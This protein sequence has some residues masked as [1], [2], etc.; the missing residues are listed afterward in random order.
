MMKTAAIRTLDVVGLGSPARRVASRL[1]KIAS[2]LRDMGVLPWKPLVPEAALTGCLRHALRELRRREP[3]AALGD[4]LEF[5]VSRG[6]SMACAYRVLQEG[7]PPHVRLIGFDSFEGMPPEAACEGW[8]PGEFRSTL[9]ATRRHLAARGV[10]LGR[11]ALVEGWFKD[12]LTPATRARLAIGKASLILVDCDIYTASKEALAFSE[13]LIRGHA[14][15]AFDDW[16]LE[17]RMR[18]LGQKEAFEEFLA[19]HPDIRAEPLAAYAPQARVFMLSRRP[20]VGPA[21]R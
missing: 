18:S 14:V 19:A 10:D 17:S 7:A 21:P 6:T 2:R 20:A 12:T 9:A 3:A 5:G 13:P 8:R 16:G 15:V 11:V 1:P 4:Y